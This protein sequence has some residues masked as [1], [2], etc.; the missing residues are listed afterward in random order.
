MWIVTFSFP[1]SYQPNCWCSHSLHRRATIYYNWIEKNLFCEL[2]PK[3]IYLFI[4]FWE[5]CSYE[6]T[7]SSILKWNTVVSLCEI[8]EP[9]LVVERGLEYRILGLTRIETATLQSQSWASS[10]LVNQALYD[11]FVF[12]LL[13]I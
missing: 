10:Q 13:Y 2:D 7:L 11:I 12:F 8:T 9:L 4:Y 1:S 3:I 5:D 6:A